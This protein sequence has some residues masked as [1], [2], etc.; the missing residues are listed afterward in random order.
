MTTTI[1]QKMNLMKQLRDS[2]RL[3]DRGPLMAAQEK[4]I[5]C[6][7]CKGLMVPVEREISIGSAKDAPIRRFLAWPTECGCQAEQAALEAKK[8]AA[9]QVRLIAEATEY[10]D[11]LHQAGLQGK[12]KT[13]TFDS[14]NPR[15]DW[16]EGDEIK[17]LTESWARNILS[18]NGEEQGN[19]LLMT[20]H[21]GMGKS[22]LGAAIIR[23]ALDVGWRQCYFRSWTEYL[24]RLQAT[25]DKRSEET[26]A[27][28][29]AELQRG[30]L[31]VI[32]DLDK[33]RPTGWSREVLYTA[34]NYRYVN[35]LNT[36]ITLNVGPGD[37]DIDAPGRL[38]I[39]TYLGR[40][41]MDRLM[42]EATHIE[43]VGPS[44]RSKVVL[45]AF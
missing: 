11:A 33:R 34:L 32:D 10:Q 22:H 30:R 31:V 9:E 4:Q 20:G 43:F 21:Y 1:N 45:P 7:Y 35:N 14:F 41:I 12:L 5:K 26:E 3:L 37:M 39:E 19:W 40:A 8:E 24:K 18:G 2:R 6:Q 42:E 16:A 25:W 28:I 23:E 27:E 17:T 29:T 13:A 15:Q 38:A 44:Y 36:V